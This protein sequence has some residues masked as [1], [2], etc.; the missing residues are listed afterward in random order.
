MKLPTGDLSSTSENALCILLDTHFLGT[1]T[2]KE[3]KMV[4]QPGKIR[5]NSKDW[6]KAQQVTT[7]GRGNDFLT[8]IFEINMGKF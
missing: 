7:E 3:P 5:A 2:K 8:Y 4:D 6:K 1:R